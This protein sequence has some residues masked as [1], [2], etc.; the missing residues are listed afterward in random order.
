[1]HGTRDSE[2]NSP[3][4]WYVRRNLSFDSGIDESYDEEA[5]RAPAWERRWMEHDEAAANSRRAARLAAESP[6]HPV[7]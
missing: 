5:C 4:L 3:S 6:Q 2:S 7:S 1:M